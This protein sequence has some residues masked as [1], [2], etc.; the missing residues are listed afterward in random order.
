MQRTVRTTSGAAGWLH[1]AGWDDSM[2][3]KYDTAASIAG[4]PCRL[5]AFNTI[6]GT[7]CEMTIARG[8]G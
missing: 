3:A 7:V 4:Q 5:A 6:S 2:V 1:T 8:N